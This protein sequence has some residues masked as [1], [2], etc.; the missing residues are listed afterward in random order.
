MSSTI[1]HLDWPLAAEVGRSKLYIPIGRF[2]MLQQ[3]RIAAIL[4][5]VLTFLTGVLYPAIVTVIAQV[6]FPFQA[7]GSILVEGDTAV[8][9]DLIGQS[10]SEPE[11]F[12]GRLSS[13][14]ET[15][16]NAAASAGSNFGSLNPALKE[17]ATRRIAA[18]NAGT[19]V[20]GVIPI[21]I[22]TSSASGLD[23]HISPAAAKF[24]TSRVAASRKLSESVVAEL[25]RKHTDGREFG[26]L[27]EPRVNVL[28]LNLALDRL[29]KVQ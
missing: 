1:K 28:Q 10:F 20:D 26:I 8:G 11:Y 23:P 13:T 14:P 22:V 7:N 15:P 21:D 3:L 17:T 12:W 27:G 4:L 25:I 9:S 18:F 5:T 2:F 19:T 6:V 29:L 16:Y 24:Q